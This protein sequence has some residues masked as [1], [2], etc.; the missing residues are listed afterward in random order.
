MPNWDCTAILRP[1]VRTRSCVHVA[2][3]TKLITVHVFYHSFH[4]STSR[5][6]LVSDASREQIAGVQLVS[7]TLGP[8]GHETGGCALTGGGGNY[9]RQKIWAKSIHPPPLTVM[10]CLCGIWVA[11]PFFASTRGAGYNA[12]MVTRFR[13]AQISGSSEF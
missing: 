3:Q 4:R 12:T 7:L 1:T 5:R 9:A 11:I 6:C 10:G 2:S 13:H 8:G